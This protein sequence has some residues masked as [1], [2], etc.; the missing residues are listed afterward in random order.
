M[1]TL[2]NGPRTPPRI[3]AA[4]PNPSCAHERTHVLSAHHSLDVADCTPSHA[5]AHASYRTELPLAVYRAEA[6]DTLLPARKVWH[7]TDGTAPLVIRPRAH[8]LFRERVPVLI[9]DELSLRRGHES[10]HAPRTRQQRNE[11]GEDE[12]ARWGDGEL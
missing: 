4:L 8:L 12:R 2:Y 6:E 7:R 9:V 11:G 1:Y 5:T 10:R 3:I